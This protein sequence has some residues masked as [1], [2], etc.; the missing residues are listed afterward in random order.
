VKTYLQA[1]T[2][3]P[4]FRPKISIEEL[5]L[6]RRPMQ[7]S[8]VAKQMIPGESMV[9]SLCVTSKYIVLGSDDA[10]LHV[11]GLGGTYKMTL[12]GHA[13]GVW[14]TAV[15]EDTLISGGFDCDVRVSDLATG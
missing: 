8:I 5:D 11:Y 12:K 7:G 6:E 4:A 14:T 3:P 9:V 13:R 1:F 2:P 10:R 15:F